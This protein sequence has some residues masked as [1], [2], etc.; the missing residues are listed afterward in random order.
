M[1]EFRLSV[2]VGHYGIVYHKG[3]NT[4]SNYADSFLRGVFWKQSHPE[5]KLDELSA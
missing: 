3:I 2:E 4:I 5:Y 1:S